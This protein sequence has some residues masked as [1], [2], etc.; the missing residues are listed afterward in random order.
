MAIK[1]KKKNYNEI[2][3]ELQKEAVR[4][5]TGASNEDLVKVATQQTGN[6]LRNAYKPSATTTT[7]N[8]TNFSRTGNIPVTTT[9]PKTQ[10]KDESKLFDAFDDGYDFGDVTKTI[11][12]GG[13]ILWDSATV[14]G[15]GLITDPIQTVKT[16]AVGAGE[17]FRKADEMTNN[18]VDD[19]LNYIIPGREEKMAKGNEFYEKINALGGFESFNKETDEKTKQEVLKL[20][21]EY[22]GKT[23]AMYATYEAQFKA[24]PKKVNIFNAKYTDTETYKKAQSGEL[25]ETQQE[26]YEQSQSLGGMGYDLLVGYTT[27]GTLKALG[28]PAKI[29]KKGAEIAGKAS[30]FT[31]TQQS[32]YEQYI[33]EGYTE[34]EARKLGVTVG[35]IEV[36][37]ESVGFDQF[38]GLD[39]V[40]KGNIVKHAFGEATEEFLAPYGE[41]LAKTI[42]FGEEFEWEETTEEALKGA[43]S[44]AVLGLVMSSGGK[45]YSKVDTVIN[46]INNGETVTDAEMAEALKE[47]E[48]NEPGAIKGAMEKA[49]LVMKEELQVQKEE[50]IAPVKELNT[51]KTAEVEQTNNQVN[52]PLDEEASSKR[53]YYQYNPVETDSEIAK[54]IKDSASKT[55]ND[56][57]RSHEFVDMVV[58]FAEKTGTKYRFTTDAEIK[59]LGKLVERTDLTEKEQKQLLELKQQLNEA[60]TQQDYDEIQNKIDNITHYKTNGFVD[61]NGDVLINIDSQRALNRVVGHE[62]FHLVENET[63]ATKLREFAKKYAETKG[64]YQARKD[65]AERIYGGKNANIENEITADII[66]DYLFTDQ[67]F[68]NSLSTEQPN[69]FQ[70]IYNEIKHW[71]NMATAG[72]KEAR[73]LEQLKHSFEKALNSKQNNASVENVASKGTKTKY[74]I[75]T[76]ENG[77]KYIKVDA[78]QHIFDGVEPNDYK[79]IVKKYMNDYLRGQTELG[80]LN[81]D[82]MVN[83]GTKGINKYTNPGKRQYNF[84]EKMKL[85]PELQNVL[86]IAEKTSEGTASKENSKFKNWEYYQVDFNVNG[87]DFSGKVNIGIDS[88]GN[89]HFYEIN[90]IQQKN[91]RGISETSQNWHS[92]A[93]MTDNIPQNKENVKF[94]LTDNQGRELTEYTLEKTKNS[95]VRD[96]N[97]K[98]MLMYHGSPDG[99]YEKLRAGTYFTSKKEYAER[100]TSTSASSLGNGRKETNN[101]KV[102]EAYLNIE[103]PFNLNDAEARN[104]YINE[105]IKGGNALG[106]NPYLSDAEYNKID[107][108]DWTE[109]E[110]LKDFLQ[111]NDYDYDGIIAD[112]GGDFDADGNVSLRGESYIPFSEEQIIKANENNTRYS[113][114]VDDYGMQHRPSTD[115]GDASNFE[116]NMPDVFEHPEWYMFGGDDWY[117]K[118][119]KESWNAL[120]KVRNNPEG[121][122]TIYRATIGDTFNE[123]DWVSPSKAYAEWHN[124]SNLEGKGKVLELKVKAKDIRFAGDDLNEFGYFPNGVDE[125]SLSRFEEQRKTYGNYNVYSEDIKANIA[126]EEDSAKASQELVDKL[127]RE[128][129]KNLTDEDIAPVEGTFTFNNS[130]IPEIKGKR[131]IVNSIRNNF[132]IKTTEARELYNKIAGLEYPTIDDVYNELEA[133]RDIK[134]KEQND[135]YA[136]IQK[137]IR[138]VKL[139][140][141]ELKEQMA[142]Y[143]RSYRASLMG[144]G[145]YL[146]NKGQSI[147]EFYQELNNAYPSVFPSDITAEADQLEAIAN[148]MYQD[149][150]FTYT[151]SIPD[152][153]LYNLAQ[154]ILTDIGNNERYNSHLSRLYF[155]GQEIKE[156]KYVAPVETQEDFLKTLPK[157]LDDSY[158]P[159]LEMARQINT[160]NSIGNNDVSSELNSFNTN[161]QESEKVSENGLNKAN[162]P[163]SKVT[164]KK[165]TALKTLD[166]LVFNRNVAIDDYAKETGNNNIKFLADHVNNVFGEVSTNI[167]NVQTDNYGKTIGKGLTTIFNQARKAG[168]SEAFND[169]LFHKSNIARHGQGKGSLVPSL[170]SDL[171]VKEYEKD[172]PQFKKWASE[173]NQYNKNNLYKQVEAGFYTK[174]F[175]DKLS[176]MYDFYVPFFEDV[177][178][179]YVDSNSK[180]IGVR[181]TIKRA[182]GGA[183]RNLLSFEEAMMKQTQS[184]ITNIR[185]NQLYK[186]IVKSS[187][188]KVYLGNGD[189]K[190][191]Y[192]DE[193]G[194]YVTAYVDGNQYS[195]KVSE[196]LFNGLNNKLE[197]QIKDIEAKL[198][199]FTKTLQTASNL[200]R[201]MLTTWSPTFVVKNFFKDV[202]DAPLN[203]KYA[204]DWAKNYPKALAEITTG[205]GQ[206]VE[207]FLN[208]YGQAN[209]MG[210]YTTDSGVFD[211]T[212]SAN[213]KEKN[214]I[215]KFLQMN[216]IIELAPRYAEYLASLE[217]GTSQMEA[218]YNAREV[219]TNFGRGGVI[220]KALNRNGFTFLNA[221]VQGFNKLYRN[222]SGENGAKG[223]ANATLKAVMMGVVPAL[224]NA[225]AYDDDEEYQALPDYVKD[226]YYLIRTPDGK[227]NRIPKGRM[228]S[229]F[230]SAARRTLELI[231]GEDDAFE[232]FLSNAYSQVGIQNPMESNILAPI[233]Q[234]YGSENGQTWYGTDIV[235]SR[236]QN[237]PNAEQYD[238]TTDALSIWL[239]EKTGISPYKF[240]YV[241]DQYSGGIGDILMPLITEEGTSDAETLPEM[242][243]APIK[244]QFVVNSTSDNKYVSDVYTLSDELYKKSNSRNATDEDKLVNQYI[245]TITSEMGKLYAE[246]REVQNDDTLTKAEKFTKSQA[247]KD[248]INRLAKEGLDNYQ[249]VSKTNNYAIVGGREFNKYTTQDGEERWGSVYEDTLEEMNALGMELEEKSEFFTA[250]STIKEVQ[251]NYDGS[252]DYNAKKRDV[253][254]VIKNTNLTDD[255]KA[256]LYDKYYA[257]TE[258]LNAV[259]TLGID[260]NEY[261]DY[262][263]QE[264]EA[265]KDKYG[266]TISGSKKKKVFNYIN[267]MD[268]DFEQ[269]LVLAKLQYPSYDEYNYEIVEYLNNSSLSYEEIIALLKKMKFEVDDEGYVYW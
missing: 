249:N 87:K 129:F 148:F 56:S 248:E 64:D 43:G 23:S 17:G 147:D 116:E 13:K 255:Q 209:L 27:G 50:D 142:D 251:S 150:T 269:K 83:I 111:E 60:K 6:Q 58:K 191:L 54:F 37:L 108:I 197:Q 211:V 264:F 90:N 265:D 48:K 55:M 221:S 118:A 231:Q 44:G 235:P 205:K 232:G 107:N 198:G 208:M 93:F 32:S 14:V 163:S 227:Y 234:A 5:N 131:N 126:P 3:Y 66:G 10:N 26:I 80:S 141:S 220:T 92:G 7:I 47:L 125:Y 45:G 101:P 2:L 153:V 222:F 256:Y 84:N 254:E 228:L 158:A 267:S 175:A 202:Q 206:H 144:K 70:K 114:S 259:T 120:K 252:T 263:S 168:L 124:Y 140:V 181:G 164:K 250:Q 100:Y 22:Y 35:A 38:K 207:E 241:L 157:T 67:Q 82:E 171:L 103:K 155:Q 122:I 154:E 184:T 96:K 112:E 77:S 246:R 187:N 117:K 139:D 29:I 214:K 40:V 177:E 225:L 52:N 146:G 210:D 136:D 243:L 156:G 1:K 226:N 151:E 113:L 62:T 229:I 213:T 188:E 119:Y 137:D 25:D 166:Y 134:I 75:Q 161:T 99:T 30:L 179:L 190:P 39:N 69:L 61:D 133:Y 42:Y 12:T 123:G 68:I 224:F 94:S 46:K 135:Y 260:F 65:R 247:I 86:E 258:T 203:S 185:K 105:Y 102:Y 186:E 253:I 74:S 268:I 132:N 152:N 91:T 199:G 201:K 73:Q 76:R 16:I 162:K 81:S 127:G 216:E 145:I 192:Q 53:R 200:R 63:E 159:Y 242:L 204:T 233:L 33:Q 240:N 51:A 41:E 262:E 143:D 244:D 183:D 15:K 173:V 79:K 178:K 194:Y 217:N 8:K 180:E 57:K 18:A 95:K 170:E 21:E 115:Y 109:V 160:E 19:F 167:N 78:D 219:T 121:E 223:V 237:V 239:G 176:K 130:D 196:D 98:L 169:Y 71:I 89:K 238:E 20:V 182:K 11:L 104:I 195:A 36:G 31:R 28:A 193:N 4:N 110:D 49:T 88:N 236:L 106:I 261:L 85:A 34:E 257:S 128:H 97:G 212:K 165:G 24:K 72:S 149:T 266:E 218:L 172:Y 245:Y 138:G 9:Q 174:E 230:G 215:S 189:V 59:Q